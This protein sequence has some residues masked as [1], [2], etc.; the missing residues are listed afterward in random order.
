VQRIQTKAQNAR[1]TQ[2]FS[3][4]Y[5]EYQKILELYTPSMIFAGRTKV[6]DKN[7]AAA[8]KT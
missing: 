1:I 5:P 7:Q 4:G 2:E 6:Q 8:F 3:K